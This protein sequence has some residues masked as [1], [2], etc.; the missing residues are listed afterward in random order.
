MKKNI[1][2]LMSFMM[3]LFLASG[4]NYGDSREAA[5]DVLEKS[6]KIDLQ[7]ELPDIRNAAPNLI[8]SE[9]DKTSM[10]TMKKEIVE[11]SI[12]IHEI[13][14]INNNAYILYSLNY[15]VTTCLDKNSR[16]EFENIKN[17][18]FYSMGMLK[19]E[20]NNS[21]SY[22]V[23]EGAS[24]GG[25]ID[26][27]AITVQ[28]VDNAIFGLICDPRVTRVVITY[29]DGRNTVL[30]TINKDYYIHFIENAK[31]DSFT[32]VKAFDKNGNIMFGFNK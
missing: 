12:K 29:N 10:V 2:L 26:S 28:G 20:K 24:C 23:T 13:G 1:V 22:N 19:L 16:E 4:C 7:K 31:G 21:F 27:S 5:Q 18:T 9:F 17:K 15:N 30:D 32:E 8:K 3:A 14:I 6:G 25:D 11:N